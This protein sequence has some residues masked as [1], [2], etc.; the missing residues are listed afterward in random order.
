MT[1]GKLG[2][3]NVHAGRISEADYSRVW[4]PSQDSTSPHSP[5]KTRSFPYLENQSMGY[6]QQE[7]LVYRKYPTLYDKRM[8]EKKVTLSTNAV[9]G[10][11]V[12]STK[13]RVTISLLPPGSP[14]SVA[15]MT[16]PGGTNTSKALFSPLASVKGISG[17]VYSTNATSSPIGDDP[18]RRVDAVILMFL[19]HMASKWPQKFRRQRSAHLVFAGR[20]QRNCGALDEPEFRTCLRYIVTADPT[21]GDYKLLCERF[22]VPSQPGRI[23][24][25]AFMDV[26]IALDNEPRDMK[27]TPFPNKY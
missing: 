21:P 26:L 27:L 8:E 4:S 7:Q 9:R 25:A 20:D 13:K 18:T 11:M 22:A 12:G 3:T 14:T 5:G 19:E 24:Y 23:S 2:T 1:E 10:H 17:P 15:T 16:S 6:G